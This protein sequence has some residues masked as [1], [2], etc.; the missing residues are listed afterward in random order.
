MDYLRTSTK[1]HRLPTRRV[2]P[3]RGDEDDWGTTICTD[4]PA[5]EFQC[6]NARQL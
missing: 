4:E 1:F 2:G 6:T 3:V 5:L